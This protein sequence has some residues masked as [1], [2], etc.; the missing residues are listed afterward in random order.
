[1][2]ALED[3]TAT[4]LDSRSCDFSLTC[5]LGSLGPELMATLFQPNPRTVPNLRGFG[6][7]ISQKINARP[8]VTN[9]VLQTSR[10]LK[11]SGQRLLKDWDANTF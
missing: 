1:M 2:L 7:P 9:C 11:S 6:D 4:Q 5:P 10:P 3:R 8:H